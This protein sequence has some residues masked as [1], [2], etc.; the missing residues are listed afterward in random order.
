MSIKYYGS[1]LY[2][3]IEN[4]NDSEQLLNKGRYIE[5]AINTHKKNCDID[6]LQFFEYAKAHWCGKCS[7][8]PK[9]KY[10]KQ[11]DK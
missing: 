11:L 9:S 3:S 10:E 6:N 7:G 8:L 4:T 1:E 5:M 2:N